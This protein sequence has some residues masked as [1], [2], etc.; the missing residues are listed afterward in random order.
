MLLRSHSNEAI[1]GWGT[2]DMMYR[3]LVDFGTSPYL[4]STRDDGLV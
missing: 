3:M 2:K 1:H 4:R